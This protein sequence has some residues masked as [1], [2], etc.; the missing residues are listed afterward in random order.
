VRVVGTN[1]G[2][3]WHLYGCRSVNATVG[4]CRW[5]LSVKKFRVPVLR[6]MGCAIATAQAAMA[7]IAPRC[8]PASPPR[9]NPRS[10]VSFEEGQLSAAVAVCALNPS[11]VDA[12]CLA[13]SAFSPAEPQGSRLTT[14]RQARRVHS[15]ASR[16]RPIAKRFVLAHQW[17]RTPRGQNSPILL[18]RAQPERGRALPPS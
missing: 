15:G 8:L 10:V 4:R 3:G 13:P 12:A 9:W 14:R 17:Q 5:A 18:Q 2:E 11:A 1:G 6:A 7:Q 16:T